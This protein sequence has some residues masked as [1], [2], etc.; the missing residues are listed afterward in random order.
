V[1]LKGSVK[2]PGYKMM[3]IA[4]TAA[5]NLNTSVTE[6]FPRRRKERSLLRQDVC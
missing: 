4:V 2:T 3:T 5:L 1:A 6:F